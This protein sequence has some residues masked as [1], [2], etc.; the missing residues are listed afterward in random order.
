MA[1]DP[2]QKNQ[3][4]DEPLT[5][6]GAPTSAAGEIP[7]P[8]TTMPGGAASAPERP[9]FL[10]PWAIAVGLFALILLAALWASRDQTEPG[11]VALPEGRSDPLG[12]SLD[13][14][15][16]LADGRILD[17]GALIGQAQKTQ[18][19]ANMRQLAMYVEVHIA[20]QGTPPTSLRQ[21]QQ[22][23]QLHPRALLDAWDQPILYEPKDDYSYRLISVGRDGGRGSADDIVLEDGYFND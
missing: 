7:Q 1:K 17:P 12:E 18:T 16:A 2:A 13:P 20:E 23:M 14:V 4:K 5:P 21:I 22:D 8:F 10:Q 3:V 6:P 15:A 19:Q 11:A 9:A